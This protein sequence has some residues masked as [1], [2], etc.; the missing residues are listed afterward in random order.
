[1]GAQ[2]CKSEDAKK[3]VH[4]SPKARF[5]RE[6]PP[7]MN[8]L[9]IPFHDGSNYKYFKDDAEAEEV[10]NEWIENRKLSHREV[11]EYTGKHIKVSQGEKKYSMFEV[12]PSNKKIRKSN[13]NLPKSERNDL[14]N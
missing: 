10:A 11:F 12:K 7:L 5:P 1:M 3:N 4:E 14:L 2:V 8:A 9:M 6:P 13:R